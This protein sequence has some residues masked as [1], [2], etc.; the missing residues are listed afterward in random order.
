MFARIAVAA[1][2]AAI[3]FGGAVQAKTVINLGFVMD[4]SGSVG[5]SNY[6]AAMLAL[7]NAIDSTIPFDDPDFEYVIGVSSF[8]SSSQLDVAATTIDSEATRTA[9]TDAIKAASRP[10]GFTCYQCGLDELR[11]T[12]GSIGDEIGLINM[13]TDGDDNRG[14]TAQGISD[15][16]ADGWDSLS[17]EATLGFDGTNLT[18]LGFDQTDDAAVIE[19]LATLGNPLTDSFVIELADFGQT[20]QDTLNKKLQNIVDDPTGGGG[21]STVI[22]VPAS[23]PLLLGG[24]GLFGVLRRQRKA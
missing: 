17:F 12:F 3:A 21:G 14:D 4:G 22:P 24:L 10:T 15:V 2:A 13:M 19:T 16:K 9:V 18:N 7:A 1:L 23:L 11:A 6:N 5:D 8:G 20:Y